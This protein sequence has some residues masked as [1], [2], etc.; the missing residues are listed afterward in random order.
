MSPVTLE[1]HYVNQAAQIIESHQREPGD[2]CEC[3]EDWSPRHVALA[4]NRAGILG[5]SF[6]RAPS[7]DAR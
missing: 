5:A 2:E 1:A 4:L 7:E 6:H 3:G